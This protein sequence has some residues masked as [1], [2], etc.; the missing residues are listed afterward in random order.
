MNSRIRFEAK[1]LLSKNTLKFFIISTIS[2][3]LRYGAVGLSV[4]S[5]LYYYRSPFFYYLLVSYNSYLVYGASSFIMSSLVFFCMLF[6][7]GVRIGEWAAYFNR[8]NGST[9]SISSL[10][11]FLSI[12]RSF[13][14]LTL[15]LQTNTLKTLW[16]IYF[17]LPTVMCGSCIY[18]LYRNNFVSQAIY[19]ILATGL[20]ITLALAVVMS[21][22]ISLRLAA[23]PYYICLQN[24]A[25]VSNA[26]KKSIRF[27]NGFL[28]DGVVLEYSLIGWML[29]C[30]F[31]IP[32]FY[33]I[34][35]IKLAKAVFITDAVFSCSAT[36]MKYA[37]NYISLSP[38][39]PKP[40]T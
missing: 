25:S 13:K 9:G 29:S 18:Y 35:Y 39:N 15:F 27:T 10:F 37:V 24:N 36:K 7:S 8:A 40:T 32:L 20:S 1:M 6:I 17:F 26:I 4:F 38:L 11:K 14:A 33:V 5:V 21:R 28:S 30:I 12:N 16:N 34:P 23:A 19:I 22:V 31:I 3:I 2:F